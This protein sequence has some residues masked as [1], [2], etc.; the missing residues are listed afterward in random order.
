M[1]TLVISHDARVC[2]VNASHPSYNVALSIYNNS[3]FRNCR[4]NGRMGVVP[5]TFLSTTKPEGGKSLTSDDVPASP[6]GNQAVSLLGLPVKVV[7]L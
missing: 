7:L 2:V 3:H 4:L 6:A 5:A 1:N